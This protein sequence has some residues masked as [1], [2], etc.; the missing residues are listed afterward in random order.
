VAAKYL[1][2]ISYPLNSYDSP[3][4]IKIQ[5]T[6]ESVKATIGVPNFKEA[7]SSASAFWCRRRINAGSRRKGYT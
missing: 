6:K 5:V 1:Y 2:P 7:W 4:K 3:I